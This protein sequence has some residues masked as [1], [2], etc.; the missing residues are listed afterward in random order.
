MMGASY[1]GYAAM[2]AAARNPDIY[3]CSI[4][5]AG[6]SEVRPMLRY[7]GSGWIARRYYRD[8]RDRIRGA[9]KFDLD[10]VSPLSRAAQIKVPVLIAHGEADKIVPVGQSKRIHEAL[11]QARIDHE[12]VIYPQEGHGFANTAHSVDFLKRVEAFLAKHNPA[13]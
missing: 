6:I 2:W 7:E 13:D 5:F 3:R 9:E 1:G 4:S 8:W 12:F 10:A 11:R